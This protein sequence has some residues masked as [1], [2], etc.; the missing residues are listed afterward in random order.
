[1][2][3]MSSSSSCP[4]RPYSSAATEGLGDLDFAEPRR[5]SAGRVSPATDEKQLDCSVRAEL[6]LALQFD[7]VIGRRVPPRPLWR[8]DFAP[9]EEGGH[10]LSPSSAES[11]AVGAVPW[12]PGALRP[13]RRDG[14]PSTIASSQSAHRCNADAFSVRY[15]AR[16]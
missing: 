16:L 11:R 13:H 1:M 9:T 7:R 3:S 8:E 6:G 14:R 12:R 2:H 10:R 5:C 15:A 4:F